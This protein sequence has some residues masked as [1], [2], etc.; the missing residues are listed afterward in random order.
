MLYETK[1]A[2]NS[3]QEKKK[4]EKAHYNKKCILET[5]FKLHFLEQTQSPI[6]HSSL[7]SQSHLCITCKSH[8]TTITYFYTLSQFISLV[9]HFLC[10]R[11]GKTHTKNSYVSLA[12]SS[13]PW[14]TASEEFDLREALEKYLKAA[15]TCNGYTC[16]SKHR[17]NTN[18]NN[19]ILI[20]RE[21]LQNEWN[22]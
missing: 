21:K 19:Y 6:F 3:N 10:L 13:F 5:T 1:T 17:R 22:H 16:T 14:L 15:A 18:K 9:I 4:R 2:D 20:S 12:P 11:S 7:Y 8:S